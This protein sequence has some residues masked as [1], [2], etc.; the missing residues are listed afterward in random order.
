LVIIFGFFVHG[1]LV[2]LATAGIAESPPEVVTINCRMIGTWMPRA[3]LLQE[4]LEL[5]LRRRL[6][7]SRGTIHSC[8]E[9]I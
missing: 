3:F 6:L 5:L 1:L 9:I 2:L 4:L 8:D 7:A